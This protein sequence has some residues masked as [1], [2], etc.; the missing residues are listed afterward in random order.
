[1]AEWVT[2]DGITCGR[3]HE[4]EFPAAISG[5]RSSTAYC[6][7]CKED[8]P[9]I[10]NYDLYCGRCKLYVSS[11]FGECPTNRSHELRR[12]KS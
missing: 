12:V 7:R 4:Y 5:G 3:G 2:L 11:S 9:T 1:M 10:D 6:R 8:G